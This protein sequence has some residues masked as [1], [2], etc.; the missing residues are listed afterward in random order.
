MTEALE[1]AQ[2]AVVLN[3]EDSRYQ[4]LLVEIQQR[5]KK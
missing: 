2:R 4:R 5:L 3:D 1:A